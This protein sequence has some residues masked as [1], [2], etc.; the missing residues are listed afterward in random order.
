[1][2]LLSSDKSVVL[3]VLREARELLRGLWAASCAASFAVGFL[4]LALRG[5]S[6]ALLL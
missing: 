3:V 1:M 6:T 5:D 4:I 2:L